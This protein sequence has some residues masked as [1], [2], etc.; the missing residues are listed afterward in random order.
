MRIGLL[1]PG[2]LLLLTGVVW[3]LQGAWVLPAT[4]MRG[5]EWIAYGSALAAVGALLLWR[6]AAPKAAPGQA[7]P[8]ASP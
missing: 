4:F 6:A 5:P 2:A 1:I 7:P 8:K 3:A